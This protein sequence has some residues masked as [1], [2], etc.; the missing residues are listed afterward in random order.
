MDTN[1]EVLIAWFKTLS[2]EEQSQLL[3]QLT[4][5]FAYQC[6]RE[7]EKTQNQNKQ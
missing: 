3:L 2:T 7:D 4:R 6:V 5:L 1:T